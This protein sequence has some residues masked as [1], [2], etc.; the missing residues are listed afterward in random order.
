ML[1]SPAAQEG[2]WSAFLALDAT[3]PPLGEQQ[4]QAILANDQHLHHLHQQLVPDALS[5]QD[6]WLR[7]R[8][9]RYC[10]AHPAGGGD[11]FSL[12]PPPLASDNPDDAPQKL[13]GPEDERDAV[14]GKDNVVSAA[15]DDD[16]DSWE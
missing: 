12:V 5:D 4:Q 9:W 6:F 2:R 10:L 11:D 1:A 3:R 14:N 15:D 8:Y 13:S 16:W 7:W